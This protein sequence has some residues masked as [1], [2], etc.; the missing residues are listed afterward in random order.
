MK[1]QLLQLST[2]QPTIGSIKYVDRLKNPVSEQ[3]N[4]ASSNGCNKV[5]NE[6]TG[7][8]ILSEIIVVSLYQTHAAYSFDLEITH[9]ISDQTDKFSP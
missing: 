8:Q 3:L 5:V 4:F 7:V 2:N 1:K 9:M 6:L